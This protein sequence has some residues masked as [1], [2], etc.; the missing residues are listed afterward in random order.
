[1]NFL[2]KCY[3]L[4]S[5]LTDKA[6]PDFAFAFAFCSL[7]PQKLYYFTLEILVCVFFMS[8]FLDLP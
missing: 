4:L 6:S 5:L 7:H 2:K 8:E 1:M 3:C